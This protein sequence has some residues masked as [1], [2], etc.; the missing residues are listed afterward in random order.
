MKLQVLFLSH[1]RN[2]PEGEGEEKGERV[3]GSRGGGEWERER[4]LKLS[5][6]SSKMYNTLYTKGYFSLSII[7]FMYLNNESNVILW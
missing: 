2:I 6:P 1:G 5:T 7:F 4:F 3:E